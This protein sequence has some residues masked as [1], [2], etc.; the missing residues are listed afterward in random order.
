MLMTGSDGRKLLD[1]LPPLPKPAVNRVALNAVFLQRRM[2]GIETAV[3]ELIPALLGL[4]P[5]LSVAIVVTPAGR[6]ALADESW[7]D[8]VDI[9]SPPILAVPMTK[10]VSELTL[11]GALA[12]RKRADVLHS[13]AMIGPIRSRAASVVSIPDVTWWRDPSTVPRATRLLWRTF[14]PL[15]ARHARRIITYS[16][17]AAH[18]ISEDLSIPLDR[19]DV[20]PLGPGKTA[21]TAARSGDELR[22]EWDLGLGPILLA[23]SGLSSHKNV[24]TLIEA[25][26]RIGEHQSD[27][28]LVVP[29]NLTE[30]AARLLARARALDIERFVRFPGWIDPAQLEGLYREASCLV[31]PSRREGF[32]LPILEAMGRGLPVICARASAMPEVAGEAALYFD[33]ESSEELANAVGL[34]LS[35]D[36]LA[37]RLASAGRRRAA[38]FSWRRAAEETLEVYERAARHP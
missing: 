17:A 28:V 13:V 33:P 10:A 16:R 15:G 8:E 6:E 21:D 30:Y 38:E 3:R 34:V 1:T 11:L 18:E 35:D 4:E 19:I 25:M 20:V 12:D 2:G 23:V 22:A 7:V 29:G 32:G 24:E 36:G 31:F 37:S 26:P 9:V 14:V 27:A 5:K